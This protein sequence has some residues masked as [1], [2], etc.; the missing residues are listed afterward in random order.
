MHVVIA[1]DKFRGSGTAREVASAIAAQLA[2]IDVSSVVMPLA[3]GGEGTV[4]AFGGANRETT[5]TGPLGD[6]V[7]AGWRFDRD[8]DGDRAVLEMATASGLEL[9]GGAEGNDPLGASTFGT[10]EL[11]AEAVDRGAKRV[12]IGL[13]GSA[14]TDGGL[15]ALRAMHPLARYR[16]IELIVATD[17]TTLFA[18]AAKVFGPQKGATAAQ[19]KLLT[20]RLHRLAGIYVEEH[21]RDIAQLAGS[22]AAGGL[23]GGLAAIGATLTPGFECVAEEVGLADAIET[24]DLVITGEGKLDDTSFAGKVVGGVADLAAQAGV[25][26]LVVAGAVDLTV[27]PPDHVTVLSLTDAFGLEAS[28]A[29]APG[30]AAQVTLDWM[31]PTT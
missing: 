11:I 31:H 7:V 27:T 15:G 25:P 30:L 10:G 17:V 18:D 16:G 23:A 20:A 4:D 9:V 1:P 5:V 6:P 2:T 8:R 3:D 22:G 28:M 21:E 24:A 14:T 29:N 26:V 12:I 13:G 19:I